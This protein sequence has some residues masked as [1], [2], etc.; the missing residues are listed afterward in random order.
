MPRASKKAVTSVAPIDTSR[1]PAT[2]IEMW[3]VKE[4]IPYAR[5]A[6]LHPEA[7]VAQIAASMGRFGF[8]IPMLVAEDGTIIA[9]HGRLLAAQSLGI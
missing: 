1:W 7:Q 6:R 3:S 4:L 5:N 2:A 8:T 9:G